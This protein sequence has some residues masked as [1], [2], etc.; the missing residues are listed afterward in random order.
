MT[1]YRGIGANVALKDAMRLMHALTA[2]QRGESDLIEALHEYEAGMLNYSFRAVENSLK[3][4]HQTLDRGPL[5]LLVSR[6]LLRIVDRL[7]PVKRL[8]AMRMGEE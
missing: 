4:M 1:P 3:A 6:T 7:P 8:M 2:A 5:G